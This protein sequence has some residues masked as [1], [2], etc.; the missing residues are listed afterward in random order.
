[1]IEQHRV[2]EIIMGDGSSKFYPQERKWLLLWRN[3]PEDG[4]SNGEV[5]FNTLDMAN[6]FL[7]KLYKKK[8]A[9]KVA[10]KRAHSFNEVFEKL[11]T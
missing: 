10:K 8:R 7:L 9:N 5:R 3:M 2:L 4:Y 6:D 1:M 11:K